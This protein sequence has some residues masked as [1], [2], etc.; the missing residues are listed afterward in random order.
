[1]A[2]SRFQNNL[3][4]AL[5]KEASNNRENI[6]LNQL[7]KLGNAFSWVAYEFKAV[8][9]KALCDP[10]CITVCFTALAMVISALLFY[11]SNTWRILSICCGWVVEHTN[12][13]YV[14]FFLWLLS[15]VTILGVG[16]RA[17]G[18]FSN[19]RLLEHYQVNA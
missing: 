18:R 4:F 5:H 9:L 15:E 19:Q 6:P 14:R 2:L 10:R 8:F 7:E 1:M 11:P 16:M 12:W 3:R 17:F 13:S